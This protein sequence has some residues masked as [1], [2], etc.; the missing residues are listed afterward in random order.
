MS[1]NEH[2]KKSMTNKKEGFYG[3]YG[4]LIIFSVLLLIK[5]IPLTKHVPIVHYK[6]AELNF[7]IDMLMSLLISL[8]IGF[9]AALSIK[10]KGLDLSVPAMVMIASSI[11]RSMDTPLMGL[12]LALAICIAIG[13]VNAVVIHYLKL[14]GLLVT[15]ITFI[16]G[17]II[18]GLIPWNEIPWQEWEGTFK[19]SNLMLILLAVI[20]AVIAIYIALLSSKNT[21]KPFW[22][23][24]LLVYAG[25]GVLSVLYVLADFCSGEWGFAAFSYGGDAIA[26]ILLIGIFFSITRFTRNKV[27]AL[28]LVLLPCSLLIFWDM[29]IIFIETHSL[30]VLVMIVLVFYRGRAELIGQSS[31]RRY[32]PR[33]WIALIPLVLL[34]VR[35]IVSRF[36]R[37]AT[38]GASKLVY[39]LNNTTVDIMLVVVAVG[40]GV[41][42]LLESKRDRTL[43]E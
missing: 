32:R 12:L 17:S 22:N 28:M 24:I 1:N 19:A 38:S 5:L 7:F 6:G 18:W 10:T 42:Y 31:E 39:M 30:F 8:P 26:A 9:S 16:I 35:D 36:S 21:K 33:G 20:A 4:G 25:S 41:L 13:V 14:P 34:L 15:S 23:S 37:L 29:F 43:A 40:M 2:I 27:L 11:F 3:K